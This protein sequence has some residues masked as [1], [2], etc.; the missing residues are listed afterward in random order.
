MHGFVNVPAYSALFNK[1]HINPIYGIFLPM[2]QL[3]DPIGWEMY[4][5]LE[6]F[7]RY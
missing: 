7:Y 2:L 5:T 4:C 1:E 6:T 3:H